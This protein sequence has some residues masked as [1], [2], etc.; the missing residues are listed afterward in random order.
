M[1]ETTG[2]DESI[3]RGFRV[4]IEDNTASAALIVLVLGVL[5]IGGM[6]TWSLIGRAVYPPAD[7]LMVLLVTVPSPLVVIF[8]RVRG[9]SSLLKDGIETKARVVKRGYVP[10]G[11]DNPA[12]AFVTLNYRMFDETYEVRLSDSQPTALGLLKEGDEVT[13]VVDLNR[14]SQ[15]VFRKGQILKEGIAQVPLIPT[16]EQVKARVTRCEQV[17]RPKSG[18]FEVDVTFR[19]QG[20]EYRATRIVFGRGT[21]KPPYKSGDEVALLVNP[22]TPQLFYLP[23]NPS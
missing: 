8:Y 13:L 9:F 7:Y 1:Q 21:L 19:F 4:V 20:Q 12:T 15:Y 16:G 3:V 23:D 11:Y 18:R 2:S 6:A 17:G 5:I 10:A 22:S 14:P